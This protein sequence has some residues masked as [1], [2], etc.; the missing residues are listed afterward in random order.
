MRDISQVRKTRGRS[1]GNDLNLWVLRNWEKYKDMS[2]TE[3]HGHYVSQM[4][5][6][7]GR[8]RAVLTVVR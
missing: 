7:K 8:P 6:L 4:N 2:A 3:L 1:S 5:E